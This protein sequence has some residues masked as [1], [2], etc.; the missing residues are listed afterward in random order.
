M[1]IVDLSSY[2]LEQMQNRMWDY[3]NNG[4]DWK[5]IYAEVTWEKPAYVDVSKVI[6]LFP[7]LQLD[8]NYAL[9]CYLTREYH[10][11]RGQIAAVPKNV[12]P[13]PTYKP[14]LETA[15]TLGVKV[16]P[17]ECSIPPREAVYRDRTIQGCLET[18]LFQN[19]LREIPYRSFAYTHQVD[20]LTES[21]DRFSENWDIILDIPDWSPRAV[22]EDGHRSVDKITKIIVFER[23]YELGFHASDGR[24][25]I[26]LRNYTFRDRP[27]SEN[28][29]M[30]NEYILKR[31]T[32]APTHPERYTDE[33]RYCIFE[34]KG[35]LIAQE[36]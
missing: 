2:P 31:K 15:K 4:F 7:H 8:E 13:A 32:Y 6:S 21:P 9:Y 18:I 24:D 3:M 22:E 23:E 16:E 20:C 25:R 28:E 33:R 19:L 12:D 11:I 10:G 17:P 5:S 1:R 36:K 14:V 26:Y 27:E 30:F 35:F 34:R 29:R